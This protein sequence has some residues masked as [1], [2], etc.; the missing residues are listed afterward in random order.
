M[1]PVS[2]LT[3]AFFRFEANK[4]INRIVAG[5]HVWVFLSMLIK[6]AAILNTHKRLIK[7]FIYLLGLLHRIQINLARKYSTLVW[8]GILRLLM[9]I[10]LLYRSHLQRIDCNTFH[11][12]NTK[13]QKCQIRIVAETTRYLP[14][15]GRV[16]S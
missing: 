15:T 7:A 6:G 11:Y 10:I 14:F 2:L 16:S 3:C 1:L 9:P 4:R 8:K 12:R 5:K 13:G